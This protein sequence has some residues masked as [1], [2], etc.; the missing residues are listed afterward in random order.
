MNW[1]EKESIEGKSMA[2]NGESGATSF[3]RNLS[4]GVTASASAHGLEP[5]SCSKNDAYVG[6]IHEKMSNGSIQQD[7][8][9]SAL[10]FNGGSNAC[11]RT[12]VSTEQQGHKRMRDCEFA[13]REGGLGSMNW[14]DYDVDIVDNMKKTK[15]FT[16][17]LMANDLATR[18]S[19][20]TSAEIEG[21]VVV[22]GEGLCEVKASPSPLSRLKKLEFDGAEENAYRS[23][24]Q[25]AGRVGEEVVHACAAAVEFT[26]RQHG[27]RR[28]HEEDNNVGR[29]SG[30]ITPIKSW[31]EVS[32]CSRYSRVGTKSFPV[33]SISPMAK[34]EDFH[35]S[36]YSGN[37]HPTSPS[38]MK[39][40]GNA[41]LRRTALVRLALRNSGDALHSSP[42]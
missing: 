27:L 6:N 38:D 31:H 9:D 37:V 14:L 42:G 3:H 18:M 34:R 26:P 13:R 2:K 17:E 39:H 40:D 24:D 1:L 29:S 10:V 22:G 25:D 11:A 23:Q 7:M 4:R 5:T 20:S 30:F 8:V 28:M 36:S 35:A 33:E 15:R 12:M 21:C 16:S 41:D 19:M 32:N